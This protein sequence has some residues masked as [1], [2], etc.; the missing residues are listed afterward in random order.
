MSIFSFLVNCELKK[1][2][3]EIPV[4][5]DKESEKDDEIDEEIDN[6]LIFLLSINPKDYVTTDKIDRIIKLINNSQNS[7][8][9]NLLPKSIKKDHK[10]LDINEFSYMKFKTVLITNF[11][12]I[13]YNFY[14]QSIIHKIK[15]LLL[16]PDINKEFVF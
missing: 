13:D 9:K 14:Y 15:V 2:P 5:R 12:D 1:Q 16:Q 7:T 10:F 3:I 11:Q 4:K 8:N 6:N